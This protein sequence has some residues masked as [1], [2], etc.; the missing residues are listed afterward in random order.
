MSW[1]SRRLSFRYL[2]LAAIVSLVA[3]CS[4]TT[5]P[6]GKYDLLAESSQNILSGTT[7][8]YTRIEKLQ[9]R[10]I[11]ET[12]NNSPLTRDSF[13]PVIDGQSF[14]LVPELRF[15]ETALDVLV[16][17]FL[18]LQAF[19]K[20]D[21]E[22][23]VD[24]AAEELAG[25][26][27]SFVATAAPDSETATEASG[28]LATVVNVIGREIVRGKRLE[29]LKTV[30]DSAQP[31]IEKLTRLIVGSNGKIKQAVDTMLGRII[32]HRN[33]MRPSRDTVERV[34]FDTDVSLVI[35]E[36][37]EIKAALDN[38]STA[39]QEVPSAHAEVR[40][41]LDEKPTGLNALQ[42]L[43]EEVQR[44]DKFYRSIK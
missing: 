29:A 22:G 30:M 3:S 10:F 44:I 20:R 37:D 38:L 24:K 39:I 14:D 27:K 1:P 7:E 2:G 16:K 8:T 13:R 36:V 4:P 23:E 34:S 31:D 11:V 12:V 5:V 42:Q 9:R 33:T 32:A 41:M 21:F 43:V 25:S 26:L 40:K 19:A 17:Y 18:V 35:G 6:V 28:I 15:R